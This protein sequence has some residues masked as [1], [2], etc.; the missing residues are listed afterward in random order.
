MY[1]PVNPS[2]T[3]YKLGLRGSKL[4]RYVFVMVT[5]ACNC[6][7]IYNTFVTYSYVTYAHSQSNEYTDI[8]YR[9]V[10]FSRPDNLG[11]AS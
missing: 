7:Y 4:Y 6:R 1:T 8:K 9:N 10:K 2:F 11:S 3:V 5:Y